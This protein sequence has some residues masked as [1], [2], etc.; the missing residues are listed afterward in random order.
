MTGAVRRV[1]SLPPDEPSDRGEHCEHAA[2]HRRR[3]LDGLGAR[4]AEIAKQHRDL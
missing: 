2:L 1:D 4:I 3:R